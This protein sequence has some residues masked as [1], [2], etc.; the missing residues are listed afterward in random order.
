MKRQQGRRAAAG[1][2]IV[3]VP[4]WCVG[5][6]VQVSR[7]TV[8]LGTDL[9]EFTSIAWAGVSIG[10]LR[11]QRTWY[12]RASPTNLRHLRRLRL[13]TR[14]FLLHLRLGS[15]C[16]RTPVWASSSRSMAS[17]PLS[18]PATPR[19][20][21]PLLS[22]DDTSR[23]RSPAT[24]DAHPMATQHELETAPTRDAVASAAGALPAG[25]TAHAAAKGKEKEKAARG[26]L[27]LLDLPVDVLREI[28]HQVHISPCRRI[29]RS[30]A[31]TLSACS[32]G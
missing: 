6:L 31:C 23:A 20:S 4:T 30:T 26:P 12:T 7:A 16:K 17:S 2:T 8:A 5:R 18:T 21:S 32:S 13:L 14:C 15:W 24:D 22:E 29:P 27:R 19:T 9:V 11:Q 28:I 10:Q 3:D 1:E 25:D